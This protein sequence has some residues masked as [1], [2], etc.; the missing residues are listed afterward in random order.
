M[1]CK[2]CDDD[3]K[4]KFVLCE[5]HLKCKWKWLKQHEKGKYNGQ[6]LNI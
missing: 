5:Y 3:A 6:Q 2:Y 4:G 1:K